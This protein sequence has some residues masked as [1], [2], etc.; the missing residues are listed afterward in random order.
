MLNF[1]PPA[2]QQGKIAS[3]HASLAPA[4][5]ALNQADAWCGGTR[6]SRRCSTA[7]AVASCIHICA[8]QHHLQWLNNKKSTR[9]HL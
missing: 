3:L 6:G 5:P 9:E 4:G 1:Q 8:G 7:A 2:N